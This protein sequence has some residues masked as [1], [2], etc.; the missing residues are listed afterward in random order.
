MCRR[1]PALSSLLVALALVAFSRYCS[2][3]DCNLLCRSGEE[4]LAR[5]GPPLDDL[6]VALSLAASGPLGVREEK[7]LEA[8]LWT[9][10]PSRSFGLA[11]EAWLPPPG[12]LQSSNTTIELI[13]SGTGREDP[14]QGTLG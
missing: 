12:T 2:F 1:L 8:N 4:G 3:F 5:F 11:S 6:G 9:S 10:R 13:P 14:L 7:G